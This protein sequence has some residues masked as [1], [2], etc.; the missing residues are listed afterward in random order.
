MVKWFRLKSLRVSTQAI[1]ADALVVVSVEL[2]PDFSYIRCEM[3]ST[4]VVDFIAYLYLSVAIDS[5]RRLF[6]RHGNH[7]I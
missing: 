4:K 3:L 7:S 1:I 6:Q 2:W 5:V